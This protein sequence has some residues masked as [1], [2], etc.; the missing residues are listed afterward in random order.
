MQ[1]VTKKL[2]VTRREGGPCQNPASMATYGR[3]FDKTFLVTCL[4]VQLVYSGFQARSQLSSKLMISEIKRHRFFFFFNPY[5]LLSLLISHESFH[6]SFRD[7]L[8]KLIERI[9]LILLFQL[10]LQ[11][12]YTCI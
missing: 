7:R 8:A 5:S 11:Y 1:V 9:S 4:Q 2:V 10:H 6:N 3:R 12:M